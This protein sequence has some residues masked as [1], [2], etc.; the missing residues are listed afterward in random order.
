MV[1]AAVQKALQSAGVQVYM[2]CLLARWN[3]GEEE[4]GEIRQASFTTASQP[5]TLD[6]GVSGNVS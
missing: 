1:E 4:C 5:L 2:G 6:C 3:D